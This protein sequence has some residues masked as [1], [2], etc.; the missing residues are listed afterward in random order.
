MQ[1]CPL[2]REQSAN[3]PAPSTRTW[4]VQC[5]NCGRFRVT[6]PTALSALQQDEATAFALASWVYEQNQFQNN[7]LIDS[8]MLEFIKTYPRPD[9]KKRAELYLGRAIRLLQGKLIGRIQISDPALRVA[10]WSF[11]RDDMLAL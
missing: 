9:M 5:Q 6:I 4:D 8:G 11:F 3:S 1:C 10:S 7:P 2:C